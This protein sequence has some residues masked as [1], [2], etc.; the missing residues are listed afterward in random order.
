[1]ARTRRAASCGGVAELLAD[2]SMDPLRFV[3]TAFAWGEGELAGHEGPDAW[4]RDILTAIRD[5]LVTPAQAMRIA[6]TSGHGIGKSALVSWLILWALATREDTRGVVT[7]NTESQLKTKT[8]AELVKW[9]R[10]SV[11]QP[12]FVHTSTALYAADPAHE[13][14]WRID[15]VPWSKANP[16]AFAGLHNQGKRLLLVFDE[17]SEID[18]MI[19]E[20][21]EGALTDADTEIL[22]VAFGNPTRNSGR[23]R[24]CFG[25]FRHRWVTRRVDSR[26]ARMT[27]KELLNQWVSDYG[28]DS[29]FV[30]VRVK[31]DFPRA[32]SMQLIPSDSIEAATKRDAAGTIF[33][34]LVLAVDVARFGDDQSV[35]AWRR[36]R[37]GRALPWE[38]HRGLDTMQLAAR[39]AVLADQHRPD[40]LFVDETGVGGGVVDRLRQLGHGV[41]GVQFGGKSDG[42][43]NGEQVAN[44]RAEMWCRMREWLKSGGAIPDDHE[45]AADLGCVEYGYTI[46]NEILLEKK[47]DMKKRGLGSPDA[48]DALALTFAYPVARQVHGQHRFNGRFNG[49]SAVVPSDFDPFG[50]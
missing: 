9:H 27:N 19:W 13:Q 28:E 7:A 48:G 50:G 43:V 49:E 11:F 34:P 32:G 23:F 21:A 12:W 17:A 3:H 31:G 1:M 38:R 14:T 18:D 2:C 29:D 22:W 5:G 8:W 37:D 46:H 15:A 30:R 47:D 40:A 44:K 33:D 25:R 35:I 41:I 24:E 10:L 39:V 20:V 4:Q 36:G 42:T 16:A 26:S 45:L 6:V